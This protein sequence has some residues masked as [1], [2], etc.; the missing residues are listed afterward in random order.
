MF[1]FLTNLTKPGPI[2]FVCITAIFQKEE[3]ESIYLGIR[4]PLV[5]DLAPSMASYS[6]TKNPILLYSILGLRD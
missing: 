5:V 1:E 4:L 3:A 6:Q 2:F